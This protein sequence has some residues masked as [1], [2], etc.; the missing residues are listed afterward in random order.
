MYTCC[1]KCGAV[2]EVSAALLA[3]AGGKARCGECRHVY[4]VFD[5]L[6][7]SLSELREA[8]AEATRQRIEAVYGKYG[9]VEVAGEDESV[10]EDATPVLAPAAWQQQP[11]RGAD[12]LSLL[13]IF[14]LLGLLGTQWAWFNR[15][16][17]AD[18]PQWRPAVTQ[19]CA[20]VNC[21]LPL[22]RDVSQLV[23]LSRDV[24]RHPDVNG[25]LL[26]DAEFENRAAFTQRYPVF[27]V[28]FTDQSGNP[29]AM[30][31]FKPAEYL[32][33]KTDIQAG[34]RSAQR[35]ALELEVLDPGD[36]AAS[37]RFE[38]L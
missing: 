10:D 18:D 32:T 37:F 4:N 22:P 11:V 12:L 28:S 1:P 24:R 38:F 8:R 14:L 26:I 25:A 9:G 17:L 15:A 16:S 31:R 36:S 34:I 13:G 27:E 23:L 2:F 20:L 19:I 30:R 35:V 3:E 7:D 21:G 33:T 5:T 29:V 6:Y